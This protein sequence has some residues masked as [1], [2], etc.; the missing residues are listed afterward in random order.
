ME[1]TKSFDIASTYLE[2]ITNPPPILFTA[3]LKYTFELQMK[4]IELMRKFPRRHIEQLFQKFTNGID[5]FKF[6][7]EFFCAGEEC[8]KVFW[9]LMYKKAF[10]D[11]LQ[12]Y[13][14][15]NVQRK[16]CSEC[17]R[18]KKEEEKAKRKEENK[19]YLIEQKNIK[20]Q[21]LVSTAHYIKY[22]LNPNRAWGNHLKPFQ[23]R[24][25]IQNSC[26]NPK[27]VSRYCKQRIKY[28]DFLQTPYWKIVTYVKR[29]YANF[30]CELCNSSE[31]PS[32]HHKT[33]ENLG[34]EMW[35]LNDLI[36]LCKNCHS[37]FHDKT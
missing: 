26:F 20:T 21:I 35:N 17:Q 36:V 5:S 14:K 4:L 34:L 25:I 12:S 3:Q 15:E 9:L 27:V 24:M 28:Y 19:F 33:Y 13:V 16:F 29:K 18:I 30:K 22:Y 6:E 1:L 8:D 10:L 7:V 2:M 23:R 32:V 31:T 11:Y 37:K